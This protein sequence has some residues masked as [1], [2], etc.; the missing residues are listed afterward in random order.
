MDR[1][2]TFA[3]SSSSSNLFFPQSAAARGV[4]GQK[5]K[6]TPLAL[7]FLPP[8]LPNRHPLILVNPGATHNGSSRNGRQS[9]ARLIPIIVDDRVQNSP[10]ATDVEL[11]VLRIDPFVHMGDVGGIFLR[12]EDAEALNLA[13]M[14]E[15]DTVYGSVQRYSPVVAIIFGR[16][17]TISNVYELPAAFKNTQYSEGVVGS[18][19]FRSLGLNVAVDRGMIYLQDPELSQY[20]N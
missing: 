7:S 3:S 12:P 14:G 13:P 4:V 16:E 15:A 20:S 6:R 8:T 19:C 2:K 1:T 11:S 9:H 5:S 10:P 18:S 17:G